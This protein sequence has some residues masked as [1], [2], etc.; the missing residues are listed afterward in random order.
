[1]A[2]RISE[3]IEGYPVVIEVPVAWGDMDAFQHVNNVVYF[4]YFENVRVEYGERIGII[5]RMETEGLGPILSWTDCKYVRPMRYPDTAVCGARIGGVEDSRM[6]LE[7][8]IVSRAQERVAAVG[9]SLGV[10]YDYRNAQKVD[11]PAELIER[12]E[13]LEGRPVPGKIEF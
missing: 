6:K 2:D 8:V 11:F 4:R 1:L 10:F 3:L 5:D 9:S 12:I 13:K 7:Y